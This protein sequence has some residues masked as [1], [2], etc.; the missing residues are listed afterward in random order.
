MTRPGRDL[1]QRRG[2]HRH[3]RGIAVPAVDNARAKLDTACDRGKG[4]EN[5]KGLA[6]QTRFRDPGGLVA[7]LFDFL[8]ECDLLCD[9][10]AIQETE[11]D[12]IH[13]HSLPSPRK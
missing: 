9:R 10:R 12:P 1:V 7:Q 5:G 2:R 13:P 8:H 6:R 4:S 3:E 11:A